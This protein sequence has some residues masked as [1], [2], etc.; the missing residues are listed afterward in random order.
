[1]ARTNGPLGS[2][3][4]RGNFGGL[5]TF[6][7]WKGRSTVS[8]RGKPV[9]PRTPVQI[10]T[11]A[12][13]KFITEQWTPAISQADKDTWLERAAENEVSPINAYQAYNLERWG[14]NKN[15]TRTPIVSA[16][17]AGTVTRAG[18]AALGG[19]GQATVTWTVNLNIDGWG[20][21]IHRGPTNTF[22]ATRNNVVGVINE[23]A[24]GPYSFTERGLT[25]GTWWFRL[26]AFRPDGGSMAASVRVSAVVT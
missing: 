25:P 20:V 3:D 15:P 1:M 11:R 12:M 18:L 22:T 8:V 6:S 9:D 10:S 26:L 7:N 2:Q 5:L 16:P 21:K 19:V 14:N 4:A 17:P 13:M 23:Q 24:L